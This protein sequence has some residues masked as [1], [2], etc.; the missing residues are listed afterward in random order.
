M[1]ESLETLYNQAVKS[2]EN[3]ISEH[4]KQVDVQTLIR[5][6]L[7][8]LLDCGYGIAPLEATN[9]MLEEKDHTVNDYY[10]AIY[11]KMMS[12]RPRLNF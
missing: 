9:E 1:T 12:R 5:I 2:A 8:S 10:R 11:R 4:P 7:T 3:Y 6:F